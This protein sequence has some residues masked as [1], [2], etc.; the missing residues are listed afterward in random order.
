[1][2]AILLSKEMELNYSRC[3]RSMGNLFFTQLMELCYH[4]RISAGI[5]IGLNKEI[6]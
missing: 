1:L 5:I 2:T 4:N 6:H 3:L